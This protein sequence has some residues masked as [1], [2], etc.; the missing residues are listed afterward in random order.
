MTISPRKQRSHG[1]G[2]AT[3]AHLQT[4]RQGMAAEFA[5]EPVLGGWEQRRSTQHYTKY[6]FFCGSWDERAEQPT[7]TKRT[8]VSRPRPRLRG[9]RPGE[10]NMKALHVVHQLPPTCT[11]ATGSRGRVGVIPLLSIFLVFVLFDKSGSRAVLHSPPPPI[12][13]QAFPHV[14]SNCVP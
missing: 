2:S 12:K 3:L 13:Y 4:T 10:T 9:P 7:P 1:C 5:I 11:R 14:R 8:R 6:L